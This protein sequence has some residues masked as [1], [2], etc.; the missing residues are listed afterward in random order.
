MNPMKRITACAVVLAVILLGCPHG[1][2]VTPQPPS[3]TDQADCKAACEHL[4]ALGCDDGQDI[5]MH[6]NCTSNEN[7]LD[8]YFKQ[9]PGQFCKNG[10]CLVT[11]QTFCERTENAG[12]WLDPGCVSHVTACNLVDTC[13]MSTPKKR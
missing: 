7:C 3:V 12:V 10:A 13:P 4:Q 2:N 9:D 6:T 11:C 5:D 8:I 1:T